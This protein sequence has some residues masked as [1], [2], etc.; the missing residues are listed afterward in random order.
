MR[1]TTKSEP[2]LAIKEEAE[3]DSRKGKVL[4]RKR[5]WDDHGTGGTAKMEYKD[6]LPTNPN[7]GVEEEFLK[8][9]GELEM[10]KPNTSGR[11]TSLYT[12]GSFNT[13][14]LV[15][16]TNQVCSPPVP[17]AGWGVYDP[18]EHYGVLG[19]KFGESDATG[20]YECEVEPIYEGL[21]S[22]DPSDNVVF[23]PDCIPAILSLFKLNGP[24]EREFRLLAMSRTGGVSFRWTRGHAD[25]FGNE[26]ADK[27]ASR[28]WRS[29]PVRKK[30]V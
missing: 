4:D 12:D 3:R 18:S 27:L 30:P 15:T 22:I 8:P 2:D 1:A 21:K 6:I 5:K 14:Q 20:N 24:Q 25:N 9:G 28:D 17:V 11:K 13:V 29:T 23:I 7:F 19:R 10:T 16:E 26:Q